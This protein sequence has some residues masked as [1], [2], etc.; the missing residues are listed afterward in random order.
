MPSEDLCGYFHSWRLSGRDGQRLAGAGGVVNFVGCLI[1]VRLMN[2]SL[3]VKVNVTSQPGLQCARVLLGPRLMSSYFTPQSLDEQVVNPTPLAIR[4]DAHAGGVEHIGPRLAAPT[5][6]EL[7]MRGDCT[8]VSETLSYST[9]RATRPPISCAAWG[10]QDS[11]ALASVGKATRKCH[12]QDAP[13]M[14]MLSVLERR[15]C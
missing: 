8:L 2:P 10:S 4:A 3:I 7:G 5:R 9:G 6:S 1:I 14:R 15:A 11:L 13:E 12:R